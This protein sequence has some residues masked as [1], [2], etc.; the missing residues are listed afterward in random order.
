M[1]IVGLGIDI[2][3]AFRAGLRHRT[4][5]RVHDA[6]DKVATCVRVGGG[7]RVALIRVGFHIAGFL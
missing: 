6:G 5:D 7:S 3:V 1:D 4:S 2:G